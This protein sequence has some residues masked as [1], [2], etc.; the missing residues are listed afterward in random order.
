VSAAAIRAA[1]PRGILPRC[2]NLP[3]EHPRPPAFDFVPSG[4]N[5]LFHGTFM[6]FLEFGMARAPVQWERSGHELR[7]EHLAC[8]SP[9]AFQKIFLA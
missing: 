5:D 3:L 4:Q 7:T 1:L 8:R 6:Q 9:N 2:G